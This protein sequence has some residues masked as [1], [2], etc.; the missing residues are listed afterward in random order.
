MCKAKGMDRR[1][2]AVVDTCGS[3]KI[4]I[5]SPENIVVIDIIS[6]RIFV[7]FKI[8]FVIFD[9]FFFISTF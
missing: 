9:I 2:H 5:P 3:C 6:I 8:D 7:Q 1:T 4:S